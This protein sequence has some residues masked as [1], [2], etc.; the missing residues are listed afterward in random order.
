MLSFLL[1][2]VISHAKIIV[3]EDMTIPYRINNLLGK[4]NF[5]ISKIQF[6]NGNTLKILA[7]FIMFII[8]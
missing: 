1:K 5:K 2:I 3:G 6:L 4:I 7:M 8:L